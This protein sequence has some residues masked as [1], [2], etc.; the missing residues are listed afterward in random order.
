MSTESISYITCMDTS[1]KTLQI[2]FKYYIQ[3]CGVSLILLYSVKFINNK[4]KHLL[5]RWS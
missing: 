5:K 4:L 2:A 3:Y 1:N